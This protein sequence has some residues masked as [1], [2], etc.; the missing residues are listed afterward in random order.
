MSYEIV[1]SKQFI[2]VESGIIPL[3]LSGSNN[4]WDANNRRERSW[5]VFFNGFAKRIMPAEEIMLYIEKLA[6]TSSTQEFFVKGGKWITA[7]EL[8]AFYQSGIKN[9]KTIEQIIAD[10]KQNK[11]MTPSLKVKLSFCGRENDAFKHYNIETRAIK[12]TEEL[13]KAI[14]ELLPRA[15]GKNVFLEVRFDANEPITF[16]PTSK[17]FNGRA[18]LKYKNSYVVKS[19]VLHGMTTTKSKDQATIFNSFEDADAYRK[20]L[21][22]YFAN[23]VKIVKYTP[24]PTREHYIHF[25]DANGNH[26]YLVK[27]T[28]GGGFRYSYTPSKAFTHSEAEKM[29]RNITARRNDCNFRIVSQ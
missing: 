17:A 4:C 1:Y 26:G 22:E 15:N 12:T 11:W 8:K 29:I 14:A 5:G 28:R 27:A 6:T 3:I 25:T 24:E 20:T 2:K 7:N 19:D 21:G 16:K 13:E 23:E 10:G 9:A 18:L